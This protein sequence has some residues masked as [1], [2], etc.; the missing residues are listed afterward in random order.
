MGYQ[1][2]CSHHSL[3]MTCKDLRSS[4]QE[5]SRDSCR[6]KT[7]PEPMLTSCQ[8]KNL[9]ESDRISFQTSLSQKVC[10]PHNPITERKGLQL[11][12]ET[13]GT[14]LRCSLSARNLSL[15]LWPLHP[16]VWVSLFSNRTIL[17]RAFAQGSTTSLKICH[18]R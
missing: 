1:D 11:T 9:L 7:E 8:Y 4:Y 2:K 14:G 18:Q 5:V 15:H 6:K 13:H 3:L 10:C 17:P 16:S 12:S